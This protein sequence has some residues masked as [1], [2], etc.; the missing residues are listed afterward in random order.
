MS[1]EELTGYAFLVSGPVEIAD[2]PLDKAGYGWSGLDTLPTG[3]EW[4]CNVDTHDNTQ[5]A[6]I[7]LMDFPGPPDDL[8]ENWTASVY[9]ICDDWASDDGVWIVKAIHQKADGSWVFAGY[10]R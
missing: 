9:E 6:A 2:E 5:A 7:V 10:T 3:A 1:L 8:P 4:L